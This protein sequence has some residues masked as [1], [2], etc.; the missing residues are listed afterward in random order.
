[1]ESKRRYDILECFQQH[2]RGREK[3]CVSGPWQTGTTRQ[4][5]LSIAKRTCQKT[6]TMPSAPLGCWQQY[7]H[8]SSDAGRACRV[9]KG[10]PGCRLRGCGRLCSAGPAG[11]CAPVQA[12]AGCPSQPLR[13]PGASGYLAGCGTR[14]PTAAPAPICAPP[15]HQSSNRMHQRSRD[16]I[17]LKPYC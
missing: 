13:S 12:P 10:G 15:V 3:L 9:S 2:I 5:C 8:R 11:P 4:S 6:H 14:A 7:E 17:I 1:M 16:Q